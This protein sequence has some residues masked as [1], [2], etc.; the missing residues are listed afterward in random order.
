MDMLVACDD[1]S[2]EKWELASVIRA[3]KPVL[4]YRPFSTAEQPCGRYWFADESPFQKIDISFESADEYTACLNGGSKLGFAIKT[5]EVYK[6]S[7]LAPYAFKDIKGEP[8]YI[9][10]VEQ[11]IAN[12][13]YRSLRS[14]KHCFRGDMDNRG[15]DELLAAEKD[16]LRD[17][18][19]AGGHIGELV[20]TICGYIRMV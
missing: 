16:L 4:Y 2:I 3:V 12:N 19:M 6:R 15:F 10:E 18:T 17:T 5:L 9:N 11:K 14:L 8:L 7:G 1:P 13:I 20:H